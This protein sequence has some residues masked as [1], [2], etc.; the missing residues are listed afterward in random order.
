MNHTLQSLS[1]QVTIWKSSNDH[2]TKLIKFIY[3]RKFLRKI[4]RLFNNLMSSTQ[5]I[6]YSLK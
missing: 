3:L 1:K 6:E 5:N 4:K 2:E